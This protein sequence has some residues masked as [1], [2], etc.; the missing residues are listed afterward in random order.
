MK[1][2]PVL[3]A[4]G[5][6]ERFWPLSRSRM[7]KQLLRLVGRRTMLEETLYRVRPLCRGGY[8]PLII[9]ASRIAGVIRRKLGTRL[10]YRMIVEPCGRNTAPAI[11]LAAA[12]IQRRRGDTLMLVL[13]ADHAISPL[14]EY[15]RAVRYAAS[16]AL[17]HDKLV[18]FGIPPSRP[19]TG[20][21][22]VEVARRIGERHSVTAYEVRRFVEKPDW[23]KAVEYCRSGRFLWNGGMFVWRTSV[24]LDE[25][26]RHMPKLHRQVQ[27]ASRAG[28]SP[29]A[30][31]RFY[32]SCD[33]ESIDY[34]VLERSRRVAAV[35]GHFL[36]DDVG[37]WEAVS[38][39]RP[40][41]EHKTTV[42]GRRIYENLC[43]DSIVVNN[44]NLT[45]AAVGLE[46]AVLVATDDAVLAI[47]RAELPNIKK[48]LKDM[49]TSGRFAASLF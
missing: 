35:S 8:V 46:N 33:A 12:E 6:G 45:L 24:I 31:A 14:P 49:K 32:A 36:W 13:P 7:P 40:G 28:F 27:T 4:G 44:S 19:D 38:R 47:S 18:V 3:L 43:N 41:T 10:P 15:L 5:I 26:R 9:T 1:M 16:V 39:I 22:Y 34:G 42:V 23:K 21:G 17:E 48:H 30:I 11:A 20:Y 37:S 25:V 2:V 29:A